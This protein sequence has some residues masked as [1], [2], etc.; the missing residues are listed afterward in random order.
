MKINDKQF[1][2]YLGVYLMQ[3]VVQ[4]SFDKVFKKLSD[5]KF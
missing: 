3:M 5:G 1:E 2:K 4:A